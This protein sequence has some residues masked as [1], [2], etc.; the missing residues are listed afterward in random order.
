MLHSIRTLLQACAE[1]RAGKTPLTWLRPRV[2][3]ALWELH[4]AGYAHSVEVWDCEPQLVGGI[5]GV[6]IGNIFFGESQFSHVRDASKIASAYLNC[7]L[8][9]WGFVLRDAKWMSSHLAGLGFTTISR[10]EFETILKGHVS[11]PGR[12]GRW[13]VDEELD[14]WRWE[15][16]TVPPVPVPPLPSRQ[17]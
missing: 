17:A 12:V 5:F 6:A 16:R 10:P 3:Q 4:K 7:H 15:P 14:V 1:P 9:H 13:E 8:A 11:L 2:M